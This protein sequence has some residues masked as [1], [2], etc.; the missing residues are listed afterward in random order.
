MPLIRNPIIYTRN[1]NPMPGIP[2][3]SVRVQDQQTGAWTYSGWMVT[4]DFGVQVDMRG[5][6]F[7]V[8]KTQGEGSGLENN[9]E[10]GGS[11]F[12]GGMP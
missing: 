4:D 12:G 5:N 11:V 1:P 6:G 3:G 2:D 9:I 8:D 7:D 10:V